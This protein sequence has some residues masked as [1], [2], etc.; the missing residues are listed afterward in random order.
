MVKTYEEYAR[1]LEYLSSGY[2]TSGKSFKR[3]PIA[4]IIGETH[5]SLLEVIPKTDLSAN[6][7]CYIGKGLRD[8]ISHVNKRLTYE[9]LTSQAKFELSYVVEGIVESAEERFV[10]FLN[11]S[12]PITIRF[13]QLELLDGIGKKLMNDILFER[14]KKEFSSFEDIKK[15]IPTIPDLQKTFTKRIISEIKGEDRYKIF[16][17]K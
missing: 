10:E 11:A 1:V 5:F 17:R 15:R 12:R 7:R 13:H 9:E 8:K 3:K 2:P 4:Q 14:R 6:E 16:V